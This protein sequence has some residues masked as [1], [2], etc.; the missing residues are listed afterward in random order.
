M[1]DEQQLALVPEENAFEQLVA[2][3]RG[4]IEASQSRVV[5][6]INAEMV[7]T[8]WHIG[9]RIV[10]EE[11]RGA[12]RA[13]YG[14]QLLIRLGRHL[15]IEVGRAFSERNLR[16]MRQF[17]QIYPKWNALRS[18]LAWTHYRILM[19]LDDDRR[20]FYERAAAAHRWSSRELERQIAS[21]L[22]ERVAA[23]YTPEKGLPNLPEGTGPLTYEET[24]RDPY[25]LDFL[26]LVDPYSEKD[27][28]AALVRHIEKFLLE[29]GSDFAFMA[30]QKR[31]TVGG[32]DY[33]ID[34]LFYHRGLRCPVIVDLKLGAM[35]P[36]DIAQMKLYL[37]WMRKYDMREGESEPIG[38]ILCGSKDEQVIELLLGD[39]ETTV[40]ERIKVAQYLLLDAQD[41]LRKHLARMSEVYDEAR[42][43]VVERDDEGAEDA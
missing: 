13:E 29:L 41:E 18:E 12:A 5:A 11:Q 34:L 16:Y 38:L 43:Q 8:Y 2:D 27:L 19:R 14:E 21:K 31:I 40:D 20:A 9:E 3:V 36:A 1:S 35:T 25:I 10:E 23:S 42:G 15:S 6:A 28:E 7:S 17:Y 37:N 4:I 33:Y 39:A 24:F 30:R 26:G 32:Q 22:A